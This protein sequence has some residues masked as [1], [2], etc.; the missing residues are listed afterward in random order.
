MLLAM[1]NLYQF[2][3]TMWMEGV[4][5]ILRARESPT[6]FIVT[7]EPV[8]FFNRRGFPSELKY[9]RCPILAL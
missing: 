7:D 1:R 8:T 2:H 3:T 4:W 6:K 5:E 9:P